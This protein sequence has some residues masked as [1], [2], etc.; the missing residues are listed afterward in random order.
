[1]FIV[2]TVSLKNYTNTN[3]LNVKETGGYNCIKCVVLPQM[4]FQKP[5]SPRFKVRDVI[6]K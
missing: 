4:G 6:A 5:A 3:Q 1:M 2:L